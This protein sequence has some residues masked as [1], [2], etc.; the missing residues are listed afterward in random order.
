MATG[1]NFPDALAG[2]VYAAKEKAPII[3]TDSTLSKQAAN[4]LQSRV[5][6]EMT[7]IGKDIE[8]QIR[9]LLMQ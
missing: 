8:Q 6:E 4:Y 3:L 2:S 5:P 9:Q 1:D 7:I